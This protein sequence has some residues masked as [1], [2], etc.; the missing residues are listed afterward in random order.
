MEQPGVSNLLTIHSAL[1]GIPIPE[2]VKS[3]EGQGYGNLKK[4]VASEVEKLLT[5]LQ[6]RYLE[7]LNEDVLTKVLLSGKTNVTPIAHQTLIDVQ[8]KV[9]IEI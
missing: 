3:F 5:S 7:L 6:S 2:L 1:S 9:G 4:A 8:T